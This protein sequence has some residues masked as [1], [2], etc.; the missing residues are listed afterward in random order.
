VTHGYL[1]SSAFF[2]AFNTDTRP[3]VEVWEEMR[4][5]LA[6][7]V[8]SHEWRVKGMVPRLDKYLRDGGWRQQ[9][10]ESAPVADQL[11]AKTNRTM[12]AAAKILRGDA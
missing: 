1:T 12:T 10:E 4:A 5:N 7:N 9:H 2:D 8:R 3:A 6:I 11:T